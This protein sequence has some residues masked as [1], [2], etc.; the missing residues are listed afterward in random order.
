MAHMPVALVCSH[1]LS[2]QV[3]SANIGV[4][5]HLKSHC[6]DST[7][8]VSLYFVCLLLSVGVVLL[9]EQGS[10]LVNLIS[11]QL[12]ISV[13]AEVSLLVGH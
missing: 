10:I 13:L 4:P 3:L 7:H 1:I 6:L 2:L 9:M 8:S 11:L 12:V 5:R